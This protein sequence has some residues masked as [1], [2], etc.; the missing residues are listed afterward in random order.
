LSAVIF[1]LTFRDNIYA[2]AV[3]LCTLAAYYIQLRLRI[4]EP[5]AVPAYFAARHGSTACLAAMWHFAF[6]VILARR[7]TLWVVLGAAVQLAILVLAWRLG[8]PAIWVLAFVIL[9]A[10]VP[11]FRRLRRRPFKLLRRRHTDQA[12]AAQS[13]LA[14]ARDVGRWPVVLLLAGLLGSALYDRVSLHAVY[15]T[16]DV[17]PHRSWW[18]DAYLGIATYDSRAL[19]P[20]VTEAAKARGVGEELGWWATR[21]YMDRIRWIPW[22]GTLD[23]S[24]PVAGLVSEWAG[25]GTKA[26]LQDRILRAA[27]ADAVRKHPFRVSIVY[28]LSKPLHIVSTLIKPFIQGITWIGLAIL[29]GAGIGALVMM[30]GPGSDVRAPRDMIMLSGGAVLVAT[31]PGLWAYPSLATMRDSLLLLTAFVPIAVAMGSVVIWGER[32]AV[33]EKMSELM[34]SRRDAK[35]EM[36]RAVMAP[37]YRAAEHAKGYALAQWVSQPT[38]DRFRAL[39]RSR[40]TPGPGETLLD[41][42]CGPGH[43]RS[44]FA[45]DY[46]GIDINPDYIRMASSHLD[47]RFMV[48][49]GTRLE[50]DDE[51][52][53]H[54]VSVATL[55]HLTDEQVVQMV[56][57]AM[58]VCKPSGRVHLL[59]AILP[60][61]PNFGFKRVVFRLDRGGYPRTYEHL[62]AVIAKAGPISSRETMAGPLHDVAYVGV[63]PGASRAAQP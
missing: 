18:K 61:T 10:L 1:I 34:R 45:C 44:S 5:G 30:F 19:R 32:R 31:L 39:I 33:R 26:A 6:L 43:Y 3:L 57:E 47:G 46:S 41:V 59:D 42:G 51:T 58:R 48:M 63:T 62:C 60:I 7:P 2:L 17:M 9:L 38:T 21:D 52:F 55:H 56:R 12:D 8:W 15:S 37:L 14:A 20:R 13:I 36:M 25:V 29:V 50:F 4:F 53:D 27:F 49:D 11:T 23:R 22:D 16:D 40:V 24:Q 54:V 28:L 35:E